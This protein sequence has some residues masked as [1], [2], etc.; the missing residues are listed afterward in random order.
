MRQSSARKAWMRGPA[1]VAL[2]LLSAVRPLCAQVAHIITV[3]N[4]SDSGPGSLRAAIASA[5]N[6]YAIN[7]NLAYPAVI[8]L[9]TPLTLG[10]SVTIAGPGASNLAIDGGNSVVDFIIND[11]AAV[12]ISD[13]T[14]Q[15]GSSLLGGGIFNA[16][17]LT[18]TNCTISNNTQGT[19]L[20]GGIFNFGTLNLG[21]SLVVSNVAST[22]GGEQGIGGGIYNFGGAL[23]ITNSI[24]SNN[25]A[26][27]GES[28][29]GYSCGLGGGI[30]NNS[31]G[32]VVLNGSKVSGNFASLGGGILNDGGAPNTATLTMT[33]STVSGN[34]SLQGGNG[35]V[36][37]ST[38][39]IIA[40]TI[41]GNS[42]FPNAAIP[43]SYGGGIENLNVLSIINS[44]IWG[45]S[46]VGNGGG[47]I[48]SIFHVTI[49]FVTIAGN[50]GGGISLVGG[51]AGTASLTVKNS[52]LA[53][54]GSAGNCL[55]A[56]GS[57]GSAGFNLADDASCTSILNQT[58]DVNSTPAGLDP[59]GLQ[60]NGGPTQT[61]ALLATSPAVD[62]IPQS[63][64]T[65][66][67][68]NPVTTDQR[69]VPR[70][71]G[72]GCD[73]GAYELEK[74]PASG[75]CNGIINGT[76][77]GDITVSNGDICTFL[78]GAITGNVTQ[79]GGTLTLANVTVGGNV[80][81]SGGTRSIGPSATITGN[82]Q[83]QNVPSNSAQDSIC[84]LNLQGNLQF[85]NNG[86]ASAI[87]SPSCPGNTIGGNLQLSNNTA[88]TEVY[89]TAVTGNLQVNNNTAAIQ[90][91]NN[92]VTGNLQ[93]QNNRA[94]V[95][96][97]GNT[98]NRNLQ[99][100]GNTG[101]TGGGNTV[102]GNKQGQCASF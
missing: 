9:N 22:T 47:G 34:L 64:C 50:I 16:G 85:Q 41:S 15:H 82:L 28:L 56:G 37:D 68:G 44:T 29:C 12:A 52:I 88:S 87:G 40:S 93:V 4:A 95:A 3:T 46:V 51:P 102:S 30:Y 18:L 54:N 78:N 19:Q 8:L 63:S 92:T 10:P 23:N 66:T 20:G 11:G 94:S 101:I 5:Q 7:F 21:N 90:V 69:G 6:G 31:T 73:I 43:V 96:I 98:V 79:S 84:G 74:I 80:Q 67:N 45:N 2:L 35:I 59:N 83:M 72:S 65:D 81:A 42:S 61:V 27:G 60:N 75:I 77:Q 89:G 24:I 58:G 36:N 32:T 49:A 26:I 86:I 38:M 25:S 76:F 71:Q 53:S 48:S 62:P 55:F 91:D 1:V 70:P 57:G 100:G 97:F 13:L 17:T 39:T 99:C 14:I 33:N